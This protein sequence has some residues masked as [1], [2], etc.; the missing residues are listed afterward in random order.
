MQFLHK[1]LYLNAGD[2]VVVDCSH[3]SNILL[4]TDS[5][6]TNYKN[7]R[8]FQHHGGGGFFQQ[9]PARLKAPQS[10]YWNITIDLGGGS[11]NV[12]HS[13]SVIPA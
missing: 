5:N 3:Q 2:I 8:G 7:G 11:G 13:I 6:F 10:G 1:R 9:L 4:T 12:R